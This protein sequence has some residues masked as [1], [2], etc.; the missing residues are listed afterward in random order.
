VRQELQTIAV[1]VSAALSALFVH[2]AL[3]QAQA[4]PMAIHAATPKLFKRLI[5]IL[6]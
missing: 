1:V 6:D 2:Y 3:D 5:P 4:S